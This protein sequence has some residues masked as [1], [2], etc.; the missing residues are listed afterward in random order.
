V[1]QPFDRKT[2]VPAA[3][4]LDEAAGQFWVGQPWSIVTEGKN[5]S[6]YERNRAFLNLDGGRFADVSFLSGT[7]SDGDGRSAVAADLNSDGM[8]DLLVRQAGGGPLLVF[9]NRFPS[10]HYLRVSLRG[11]KS[12]GLGVGARLVAE[13]A[14]RRI[15]R[16]L[17]PANAFVSQTPHEVYF[18]LD[19]ATQVDRLTIRWPSGAIEELSAVAV[20]RHIVVREG[21]S[22]ELASVTSDARQS[23]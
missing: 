1:A 18:G 19:Q 20:D 23:Q 11:T 5:L 21:E 8:Q 4:P 17:F 3:G 9:L 10:R 15:V 13:V 7:D 22:G 16:D 6:A 2:S 12:N 14:G